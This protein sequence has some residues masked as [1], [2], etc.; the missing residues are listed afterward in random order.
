[1]LG[2]AKHLARCGQAPRP[3]PRSC[4]QD[5]SGL[6]SLRMLPSWII[7]KLSHYPS[8][9]LRVALAQGRLGFDPARRRFIA[10]GHRH[11]IS[12]SHEVLGPHHPDVHM[13]RRCDR[14]ARKLQ[15]R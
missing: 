13:I 8:Q 1:M 3:Q 12:K 10:F 5:P 6:K 15:D 14:K 4:A 9:R 2:F 11:L 7:Y